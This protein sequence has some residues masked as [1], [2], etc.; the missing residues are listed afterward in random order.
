MKERPILFNAPMVRALLTGTKTQ[1][2]RVCKQA[3]G[4]SYVVACQDPKTYSEGQKAPWTTP[5]WFGDEEGDVQFCCSYGQPGDRLWVRENFQPFLD[6]DCDG[7]M[8]L[9]NWKTG[10]HYHCTYPA[11]DGIHEFMDA[12]DNLRSTVKPSIHMPRV[13]SRILLEVTAVR[14]ERLQDISEADA[15]SEGVEKAYI[16]AA[17][18]QRWVMYEHD[19]GTPGEEIVRYVGPSHT[20]HPINSYKSL[21]LNINGPG[22]WD[23]NPWVWVIEFKRVTP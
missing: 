6:D 18:R 17:H 23:V 16:D 2:R 4:L 3:D 5:G 10:K 11:T 8:R 22:S 19:D 13:A 12:D 15:I 21:W 7:D 1:T 14:V 20:L 9:A